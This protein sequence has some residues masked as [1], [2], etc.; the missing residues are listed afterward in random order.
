MSKKTILIIFV[1]FIGYTQ[2]IH[3]QSDSL[4]IIQHLQTIT[5]TDGYRNYKNVPLLNQT[6]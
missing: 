2:K 4:R 6:A 1:V 3:A 5:K